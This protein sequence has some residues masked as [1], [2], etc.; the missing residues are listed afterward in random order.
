[1]MLVLNKS[2]DEQHLAYQSRNLLGVYVHTNT[3]VSRMLSL[4]LMPFRRSDQ[5]IC[6]Q[7]ICMRAQDAVFCNQAA[8][9]QE[10]KAT[11]PEQPEKEALLDR[12]KHME[13]SKSCC[14][15]RP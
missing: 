12:L 15:H 4:W 6:M 3:F 13:V 2:L 1:M 10:G 5:P 9:Q 7:P 14:Y 11:S 8:A